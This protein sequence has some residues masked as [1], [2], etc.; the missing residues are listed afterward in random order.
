MQTVVGAWPITEERLLDYVLKAAREA[1]ARTTWTEPDERYEAALG[2]L[3]RS[4]VRPGEVHSLISRWVAELD[5]PAAA[6]D[7][8]AKLVQLTL[9]GVPDVYQGCDAVSRSLVDPDN[10]R[11]VDYAARR[12]RL[13]MLDEGDVARDLGDRKLLVT[14]RVLRLRR[15]RPDLFGAS[16]GYGRLDTGTSHALAY[17]RGD[18]LLTIVTR[19]PLTLTLQGGWAGSGL[20]LPA[21]RWHDVLT[22]REP[23]SAD[24]L[25]ADLFADLPV[26]LLAREAP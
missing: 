4:V 2:D 11:S 17:L 8:A 7:L 12:E 19:W 20:R 25:Y 24:V 1:K 13:R 18:D 15:E 5:E 14:S 9:P 23:L 10:R 26:A 3:V 16:S 22:D 21:G 6:A